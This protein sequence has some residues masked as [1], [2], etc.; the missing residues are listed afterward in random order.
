MAPHALRDGAA[1]LLGE[2]VADELAMMG[3]AGDIP[4]PRHIGVLLAGDLYSSDTA[5]IRGA[6]GDV[7]GVWSAFASQFRWV[8]GVAGNH[9]TFGTPREKER[10][11]GQPAI[12]LVD[13]RTCEVDGL[14]I[15]GVSLIS[16]PPEKRG[17]REESSQVAMVERVLHEDP[18]ILVLH[19]GPDEPVH[20]Q[21]GNSTLRSVVEGRNGLLVVCGH[22]HWDR[23]FATLPG[24]AQVL[25]VDAR[26]V[27]LQRARSPNAP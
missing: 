19:E 3:E 2:V 21:H 22:S 14:R 4:D 20:G 9:D 12:H 15:G 13:G 16:G 6:S 27:L 7:R 8:A 17:R 1:A 5:D 18:E 26:A 11:L 24:G 25:N 10:L 23:P